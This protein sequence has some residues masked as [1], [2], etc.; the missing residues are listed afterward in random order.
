MLSLLT[1][2]CGGTVFPVHRLDRETAGLMGF[3]RTAAAAGAL[4][5]AIARG[6][7][8]KEYLCI[9][10]G[11]P[12]APQGTLR[13]LLFKDSSRGKSFVVK[14]MRRGVKEAVLD[15]YILAERENTSLLRVRL[16]TGRTHQIRVQF[17]SRALPLLG[18]RKYGG[19]DGELALWS[20]SLS[21]PHPEG[22]QPLSFSALPPAEGCWLPYA[23]TLGG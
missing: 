9:V 4:S 18:D 1:A 5:A 22:K 8:H 10:Q 6:E 15:Y 3:A 16:H 13:D 19:G 14:R 11:R 7:F 21:F 20:R 23:D 12:A 2:Q 17:A